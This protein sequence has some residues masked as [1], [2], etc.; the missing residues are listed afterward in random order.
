MD[1]V[2]SC[3][4][5]VRALRFR[6]RV[7][8]CCEKSPMSSKNDAKPISGQIIIIMCNGYLCHFQTNGR[9]KQSTKRLEIRLVWSPCS[10][11]RRSQSIV[12]VFDRTLFRLLRRQ[13]DGDVIRVT[14]L[15]EF[16]L[17]YWAVGYFGLPFEN[18]RCRANSR[19]TFY[20]MFLLICSYF[21]R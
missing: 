21:S 14:R 13:H 1:F 19:P 12:F 16:A 4:S 15:G 8:R 10:E 5:H 17:M 18:Y 20:V 11:S 2:K 3:N 7:T 9:S 6:V